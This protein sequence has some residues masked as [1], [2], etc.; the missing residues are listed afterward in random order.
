MQSLGD[1][2][3]EGI[4]GKKKEPDPFKEAHAQS[5]AGF[6]EIA[7][8]LSHHY[9]RMNNPESEHNNPEEHEKAYNKTLKQFKSNFG[10]HYTS[11]STDS[12]DR[13]LDEIHFHNGDEHL[14][15]IHNQLASGKYNYARSRHSV[16]KRGKSIWGR[17][18]IVPT[19][20]SRVFGVKPGLSHARKRIGW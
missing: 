9:L 8:K 15:R 20:G 1:F 14:N 5:Q 11:Q 2:M 16:V 10:K 4:F 12:A 7:H 3:I 6:R 19:G 13:L 18:P 17:F